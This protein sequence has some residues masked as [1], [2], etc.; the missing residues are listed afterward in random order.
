MLFLLVMTFLGSYSLSTRASGLEHREGLGC[1]QVLALVGK[2]TLWLQGNAWPI[3][4]KSTE[5]KLAPLPQNRVPTEESIR[6]HNVLIDRYLDS[7]FFDA[8][9]VKMGEWKET[10]RPCFLI[11]LTI[12]GAE[13]LEMWKKLHALGIAAEPFGSFYS[14]KDK[15]NYLAVDWS[16]SYS[17]SHLDLIE[18]QRKKTP[19]SLK[20]EFKKLFNHD[21]VSV[22]TFVDLWRVLDVL[23]ENNIL[24]C[25][26]YG[27]GCIFGAPFYVT[28]EGRVII[29]NPYYLTLASNVSSD[30]FSSSESIGANIVAFFLRTLPPEKRLSVGKDFISK[31]CQTDPAKC[32][33]L[34]ASFRLMRRDFMLKDLADQFLD[35][36]PRIS[37]S[38]L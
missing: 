24:I 27:G 33:R 15:K 6:V 16:S 1:K 29:G 23:G 3:L 22:E 4:F 38:D 14:S 35:F 34:Q 18:V 13:L 10:K 9:L 21:L 31:L 32:R 26:L 25:N 7:A 30:H 19:A 20:P 17:W 5:D 36:F 28:H 8:P 2:K 12:N 37:R 11:E